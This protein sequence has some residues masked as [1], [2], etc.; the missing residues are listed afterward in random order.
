MELLGADADLCAKAKFK[1]VRKPRGGIHVHSRCVHPVQELPGIS[2][3]PGN[4][5]FGMA[6][7]VSVDMGNGLVNA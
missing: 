1:A 4:N 3:I 5:G 2:I 6:G 7:I